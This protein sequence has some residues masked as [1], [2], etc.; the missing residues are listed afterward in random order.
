MKTLLII[1]SILL[2]LTGKATD[3]Y[4]SSTGSDAAAGTSSGTAWQTIAKFNAT[5]FAAGDNIYFKRGDTFNGSLL[6][7]ESGTA[8]NR[9]TLDAY[10]TGAK[11][12]IS[13]LVTLTGWVN[14]G[15]NIWEASATTVKNNVN[16]LTVDNVPFAVGRTPNTG[17]YTYQS[18]T[19]TQLTSSTMPAS[20]VGAELVWK[21]NRFVAQKGKITVQA[22]TTVTYIRTL[23]IDNNSARSAQAGTA[24]YG[25]FLQRSSGSL[26]QQGEWFFDTTNNKMQFYSTVNPAT[27]TIKA[28]YIDTVININDEDY[29]T[30]QNIAVEGGGMYGIESYGGNFVTIDSCDFNNNTKAIYVW[31]TN[32]TKLK[33]NTINNSFQGAI[34]VSNRQTKRIEVDSNYIQNTGQLIGMGIYWSNEDLKTMVIRT[35]TTRLL[36]YVYARGNTLINNGSSGIEFQGSNVYV[37]RNYIDT[38]CTTLDDQGAIYTFVLNTGVTPLDYT[39]RIIEYNVCINGVGSPDG[40]SSTSADVAGIYM[41]DQ[42]MN[43]LAQ[44]NTVSNVNGNGIQLNNPINVVFKYNTIYDAHFVVSINK[45]PFSS[46]SGTVVKYNILFQA[47]T[48]QEN[49]LHT[50]SNLLLPTPLTIA[51]SLAQWSMDSNYIS[52]SLKS[53]Y[54]YY[55]SAT[56]GAY[57]FPS[58]LSLTQWRTYG[59]D[60]NSGVTSIRTATLSNIRFEYNET[61]ADKVVSLDGNSYVTPDYYTYSGTLTLAPYTSKI[62]LLLPG[63]P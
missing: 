48:T 40:T 61:N 43:I 39:N 42:T 5:T 10:G 8:S 24:G 31:N 1:L 58:N 53:G 14:V 38:W 34:L 25:Y 3:Y 46:I 22:G 62:L 59:N 36:N 12:I 2:S 4:F 17:Y 37:A 7:N 30:V 9:I 41:D 50:N 47:D 45:K 28:S 57:T 33:R 13:G 55:Y 49:F 56:G 16:I 6:L 27:L 11:P 26:D 54:E 29:I 52:N 44:Y 21:C 15:G 35:D 60:V 63:C 32:D 18:A 20:I 51:Q 19:T 23:P